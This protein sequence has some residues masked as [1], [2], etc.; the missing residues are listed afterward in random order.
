[1]YRVSVQ[2]RKCKAKS[3]FQQQENDLMT[4]FLKSIIVIIQ[5]LHFQCVNPVEISTLWSRRL[6]F[7]RPKIHS[8]KENKQ[9]IN[10]MIFIL[11]LIKRIQEWI[12]EAKYIILKQLKTVFKERYIRALLSVFERRGRMDRNIYKKCCL[13]GL[14]IQLK[15]ENIHKPK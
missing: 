9:V 7:Q 1:M 8:E 10:A 3:N 6:R 15:L 11:T 4:C 12:I 14:L 13:W 2:L 5:D